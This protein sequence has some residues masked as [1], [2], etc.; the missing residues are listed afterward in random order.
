MI[1]IGNDKE[2]ISELKRMLSLEFEM[3]DLGNLK[4]FRGIEVLRSENGI[5][6][7]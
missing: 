4:Y 7:N 2:E 3:K 1:V 6:I 5:F